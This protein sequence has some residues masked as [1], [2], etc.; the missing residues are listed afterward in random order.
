MKVG[1]NVGEQMRD[2]ARAAQNTYSACII[3]VLFWRI[4]KMHRLLCFGNASNW[5]PRTGTNRGNRQGIVSGRINSCSWLT[6]QL[7]ARVRR[8]W[9][10]W[11]RH[12]CIHIG[13]NIHRDENI[14]K[15]ITLE[16]KENSCKSL[17]VVG[18]VNDLVLPL[19]QWRRKK[20]AS[21]WRKISFD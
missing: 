1:G 15:W 2:G 20:T 21:K 6:V 7:N 12:P 8:S 17:W 14:E 19:K 10:S 13:A 4:H 18:T 5:T 16:S 3:C 11:S 9:L